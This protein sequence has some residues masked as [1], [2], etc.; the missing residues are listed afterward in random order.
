[1]LDPARPAGTPDQVRAAVA[2]ALAET[3]AVPPR[4]DVAPVAELEREP[5]PRPS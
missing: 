4:I 5:G 1:M 2:G 3:G